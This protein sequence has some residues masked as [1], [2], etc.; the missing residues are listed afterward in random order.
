MKTPR[1][2]IRLH[3]NDNCDLIVKSDAIIYMEDC[4][5]GTKVVIAVRDLEDNHIVT[6][7]IPEILEKIESIG[8]DSQHITYPR[9]RSFS[10]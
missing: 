10:L 9:F 2:M 3:T 5:E 1:G 7:R 6:E 8:E 4:K